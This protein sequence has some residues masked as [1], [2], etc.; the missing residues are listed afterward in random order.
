MNCEVVLVQTPEI[1]NRAFLGYTKKMLGYPIARAAD[2]KLPKLSPGAHHLA[3]IAAFKD[4]DAPP[5]A[6]EMMPYLGML[7]YGFLI[8]ADERD[9]QDI[10]QMASGC[11]FVAVETMMRGM[12]AALVTGSLRQWRTSVRVGCQSEHMSPAVRECYDKIYL[13]FCKVGLKDV[14]GRLTKRRLP[15]QTFLLEGPDS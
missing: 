3:C 5:E 14:F 2:Q 15:D 8:M 9:M 12:Q 6:S 7:Q 11:P 4:R 1:D 13:A 10:L